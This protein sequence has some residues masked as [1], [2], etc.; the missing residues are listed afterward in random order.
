MRD[1]A[2]AGP[3]LKSLEALLAAGQDNALLRYALGTACMRGDKPDEAISHLQKA[4]DFDPAYSAAWKTLGQALAA[5][6]REAEA[7]AAYREGIAQARAKGDM[8]TLREMEVFLKR[9]RG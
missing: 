7:E 5:A 4:L 2:R 3:D 1:E 8:Q 6:G 9:L